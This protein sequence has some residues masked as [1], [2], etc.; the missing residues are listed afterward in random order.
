MRILIVIVQIL[1]SLFVTASLMPLVFVTVPAAH[2]GRV[3]L[4]IMLV[5]LAIAFAI[6]SLVWPGRK[7][8][9]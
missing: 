1:V 5:M 4:G 9:P 7:R 8:Q 2:D 3:G 6:V